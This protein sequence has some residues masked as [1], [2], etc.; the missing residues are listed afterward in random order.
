KKDAKVPLVWALGTYP[1]GRKDNKI[2]VTLFLLVNPEDRN[3]ESQAIF[4]KNKYYSVG[5]KIVP[6]SYARKIKPKY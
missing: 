3:P 5:G 6:G 4:K 1:P 2:E